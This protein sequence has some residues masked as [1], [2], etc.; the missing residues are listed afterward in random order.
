MTTN[1]QEQKEK[2]DFLRRFTDAD[3]SF[4]KIIEV[5]KNEK[6]KET[7]TNETLLQ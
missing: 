6:N 2:N 4:V 1:N 7:Q 3:S 5:P